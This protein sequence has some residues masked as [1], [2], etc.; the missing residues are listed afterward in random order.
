VPYTL[1]MHALASAF[2]DTQTRAFIDPT[3]TIADPDVPGANLILD[4]PA[5][6]THAGFIP[7]PVPEPSAALLLL[8]ALLIV[9]SRR[10]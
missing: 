6:L 4:S 1:K 9:A 7:P 8:P 10:R 2:P 3:F 5:Q